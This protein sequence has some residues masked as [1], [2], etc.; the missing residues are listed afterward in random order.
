MP[1]NIFQSLWF[2][3]THLI[4]NETFHANITPLSFCIF[5]PYQTLKIHFWILSFQTPKNESALKIYFN[6]LVKGTEQAHKTRAEV[7]PSAK[8]LKGRF[9]IPAHMLNLHTSQTLTILGGKKKRH[10]TDS[11]RKTRGSCSTKSR[12]TVWPSQVFLEPIVWQQRFKLPEKQREFT[13]STSLQ[14]DGRESWWRW[15]FPLN[16]TLVATTHATWISSRTA[17]THPTVKVLFGHKRWNS[18]TF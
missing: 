16:L 2:T 17:L 9:H 10:L 1:F 7:L 18:L 8:A 12:N 13:G 5:G 4:E 3:N 6:W 14:I 15:L 11:I